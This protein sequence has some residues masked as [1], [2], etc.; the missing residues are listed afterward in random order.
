MHSGWVDTRTAEF[1]R[2]VA[3]PDQGLLELLSAPDE[4][5]TRILRAA[6]EQ[7]EAAGIRRSTV[8]DVSR[9]AGLGRATV[10][11]RFA[12]KDHLVDAVVLTEVLRYLE[13]DAHAQAAGPSLGDRLADGTAYTVTF[14]REHRL[15]NRLLETEPEAILPSFTIDGGPI[16]DLA[17]AHSAELLRSQ[18]YQDIEPTR[19]QEAHLQTVA[20]I[21]TRLTISFILTQHTVIDL[22]SA[23]AAREFARTYMLPLVT[24]GLETDD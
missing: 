13:G 19:K 22:D 10:Y 6:L 9:R 21:H 2:R 14:L 4:I 23:E 8:D 7:F 3:A 16:I 1:V 5:T 15:L 12:T 20:E 11:R 17:R 18:I 24:L